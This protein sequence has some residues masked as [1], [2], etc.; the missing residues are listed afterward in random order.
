MN[1]GTIFAGV[2]FILTGLLSLT[3]FRFAAADIVMALLA[4]L[5]GACLLLRK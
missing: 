5:A 1:W 2:W 3:N 4:L